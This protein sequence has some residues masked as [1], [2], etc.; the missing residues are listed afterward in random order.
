MQCRQARWFLALA[1]ALVGFA[2]SGRAEAYP[3]MIRHE[4]TSCAGCH[5][6]PSGGGLLTAYG[7]TIAATALSSPLGLPQGD[8]PGK[9][10]NFLFGAVEMPEEL[11]AQAWVRSGFL[12]TK[13]GPG[14]D[15]RILLMRGDVGAHM[16]AGI[17]RA[18]AQVGG[19][20]KD[21]RALSQ[22]A[23]V[24][25]SL[26]GPNLVSREHWAGV[27]VADDAVLIRAGRLN[28]PF[29]IRG[30]EHNAWVRQETRTDTNQHQQHGVAASYTGE[31]LRGEVM[32]VAG[33]FQL[34][35]DAYRERGYSAF[36]EYA[37]LPE[38]AL[39]VSSNITHA[40]AD[41]ATRK[42]IFRQAHGVFARV[43]PV[44][45]LVLLAEANA[46]V[47]SPKGDNASVDAV[48]MVQADVEPWRGIH[49]VGAA[50]LLTDSRAESTLY[51]GWLGGWVFL[52]A[53]MDARLD[54]IQRG[55]NGSQTAVLFQLHG[56]L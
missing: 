19:A 40:S 23:W 43:V 30:V 8:D 46:I 25:G 20:S 3:W 5:T 37:F 6:D 10:M 53:H 49:F 12:F 45:P 14:T 36:A 29:G 51:G 48:G 42:A 1:V 56:W 39:G 28:L 18:S 4:Y 33:N 50:E 11:D 22:E 47:R 26:T 32:G 21:G 7:R 31:K 15:S 54:L 13:S 24:T 55:G 44:K 41:V 34:R 16:H 38:L 2:L 27:A 9:A 35:P 52:F 17:F